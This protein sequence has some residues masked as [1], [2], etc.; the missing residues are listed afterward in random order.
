VTPRRP[1]PTGRPA[2]GPSQ[3]PKRLPAATSDRGPLGRHGSRSLEGDEEVEDRTN[4]DEQV[5][6]EVEGASRESIEAVHRRRYRPEIDQDDAAEAIVARRIREAEARDRPV[7]L[8]DHRQFDA[9]VRAKPEEAAGAT[10]LTASSLRQ[11]FIWR[12]ILGPPKALE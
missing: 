9:K 12:E 10:R 1:I 4:F 7:S 5:A 3:G 11:A 8:A 6:S 2:A